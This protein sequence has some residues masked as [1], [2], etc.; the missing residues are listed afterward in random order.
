MGRVIYMFPRAG[1]AALVR[2]ASGRGLG[3]VFRGVVSRRVSI[4]SSDVSFFLP[5]WRCV[6]AGFPVSTFVSRLM[7]GP[8][9]GAVVS[10]LVVQVRHTAT[11][12]FN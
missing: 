5:L 9:V 4:A 8:L 2:G 6:F 3:P 1:G 11:T 12:L 7:L 10:C